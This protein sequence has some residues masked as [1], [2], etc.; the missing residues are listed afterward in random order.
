M[1]IFPPNPI[2]PPTYHYNRY[3]RLLT[4]STPIAFYY[5]PSKIYL[6]SPPPYLSYPSYPSE[7]FYIKHP[8]H[9]SHYIT[10]LSPTYPSPT[11]PSYPY[12]STIYLPINNIPTLSLPTYFISLPINNI[13]TSKPYLYLPIPTYPYPTRVKN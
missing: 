8:Q 10:T 5:N 2:L 4:F 12:L 3:K 1:T 13:P 9:V 6:S 11:Y 7:L